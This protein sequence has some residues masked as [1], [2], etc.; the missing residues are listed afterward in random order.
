MINFTKLFKDT[1]KE[2]RTSKDWVNTNCPFC[3]KPVDTHC[4]GGF[5]LTVPSY[6]CWRCGKHNWVEALS[7][8]YNIS[9]L[10]AR[11]MAYNYSYGDTVI[12]KKISKG[13]N[14]KL[15]GYSTLTENEIKYLTNRNYN[16]PYLQKKFGIQGGGIWGD[17][18]YRIIIP[19]FYK[20]ELVSWTGRSILDK[21]VMKELN[22]PRYKNLSIE[23]S[24]VDPKTIL[25]NSDNSRND[26]VILV[27]GP[28]DVMRMGNDTVCSLGT[29]VTE[30]QKLYLVQ[31]YGKVFIAFDNE[32]SAQN[33]AH[34]LGKELVSLGTEVEVVNICEDYIKN[35]NGIIMPKND[36]GELTQKEVNEIKTE[37][38]F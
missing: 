22:I 33:K 25:F 4:N 2:I 23:Q 13:H 20:G 24:V 10:E 8:I 6:N 26:S 12:E 30:A 19:I 31:N 16:I 35:E 9:P 21:S 38:G 37:L 7:L 15:P 1:H 18:S 36:P 14:L 32:V 34:K 11:K 3:R 17:W 27:E 28:F 5:S 29:S